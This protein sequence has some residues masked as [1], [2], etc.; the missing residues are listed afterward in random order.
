MFIDSF[1]KDLHSFVATRPQMNYFHYGSFKTY[2]K[3][4]ITKAALIKESN[5]LLKHVCGGIWWFL[6]KALPKNVQ[7]QTHKINDSIVDQDNYTAKK[8]RTRVEML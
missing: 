8:N 1:G 4:V 5:L 2:P 7:S 6:L 3:K